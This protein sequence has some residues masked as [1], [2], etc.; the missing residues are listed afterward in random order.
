MRI[1]HVINNLG[2]GGAEKLLSELAPIMN[3]LKNIEVNILLLTSKNNMFYDSLIEENVKIDTLRYNNMYDPR[4][5][6]EIKKYIITGQYDIVHSHLFPSQYWV[7]LSRV[8]IKKK[9]VRFFTTEHTT[10]NRRRSKI[11]YRYIERIIYSNYDLIISISKGTQQN[12]IKWIKPKDM[13][14]FVIIENGINLNGFFN[15]KPL[16]KEEIRNGIKGKTKFL[17]M[18][19]R[20]TKQKDQATIIKAM[21]YLPENVILLLVGDGPLRQNNEELA[22]EVGVSKKVIFLGMRKDVPNVF[23]TSDIA[24]VSSHWE[25]FGLVAVEAMAAGKPVIAS[26]VPGLSEVVEGAGILFEKGDEIDLAKKIIKLID[27]KCLY[28]E[29]SNRCL[30]R[31]I[32]YNINTMVRKYY[33]KYYAFNK[34]Y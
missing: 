18:V 25:G 34:T 28:D 16:R 31:S 6:L 27:N 21:K 17:C 30:E 4:N 23:K 14:K 13:G 10:Y 5:I 20:F 26:N 9:N 7:A 2:C 1:L 24:I 19:G 11:Y 15:A 3:R 32:N 29:I 12:L 33:E 8:F 22:N